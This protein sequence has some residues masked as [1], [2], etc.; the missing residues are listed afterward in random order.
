MKVRTSLLVTA[1]L[2]IFLSF[3]LFAQDETTAEGER[4]VERTVLVLDP[5]NVSDVAGEFEFI[6]SLVSDTINLNLELVE[7]RVIDGG[8][9]RE[10]A[11][12]AKFAEELYLDKEQAMKF[13]A[14]LGAD[15]LVNGV[16]RVEGDNIIIGMKAYDIFTGRIATAINNTGP[17]GVGIYDTI[18]E[19]AE[20]IS[21]KI[22]ENLKPLP[23]SVI[24]VQREEI[25]V[26]T[27]IVEEVVELGESIT[28]TFNSTDEGAQLYLGGAQYVGAI[29]N[30]TFEYLTGP[31]SFLDFEVRLEGYHSDSVQVEV[32]TRDVEVNLRRLY[33]RP[34]WEISLGVLLFQPLGAGTQFRYYLIP[35]RI[36]AYASGGLYFLPDTHYVWQDKFDAGSF[37][38]DFKLAPGIGWYPG[39]KPNAPFRVFLGL[40]VLT[41]YKYVTQSAPLFIFHF[42]GEIHLQLE[43]NLPR[44]RLYASTFINPPWNYWSTRG[45]APEVNFRNELGVSLKR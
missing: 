1:L 23:E 4:L 27:K 10:A 30:G 15:V 35:D 5:V 45:W 9:W 7:Y 31:N 34:R 2:L 39:F 44:I 8:I 20:A 24:T 22:R 36:A 40:G 26:E 32:K 28:V 42:S 16:F 41:S 25:R 17:A 37:I 3:P 29:E 21:E 33:Y 6:G 13:A 19:S 38:I 11:D 12:E 18:D 43:L 14:S